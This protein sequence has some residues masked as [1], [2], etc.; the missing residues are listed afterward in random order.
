MSYRKPGFSKPEFAIKRA[1]E[2]IAL[3]RKHQALDALSTIATRRQRAWSKKLETLMIKFLSMCVELNKASKAKESL[4]QFRTACLQQPQSLEIV[5]RHFTKESER[6]AEAVQEGEFEDPLSKVN[7]DPSLVN[8]IK[9]VSL[10][11]YNRQTDSDKVKPWLKF[12]WETY[13]TV[14]EILRNNPKL[15]LLYTETAKQAFAFCCKYNRTNEFR[16]LA[17][18]LRNHLAKHTQLQS[19]ESEE[20][21]AFQLEIRFGQLNAAVTLQLWQEAYKSVEDINVTL[22]APA[23]QPIPTELLANYYSQLE[24]LFWVSNSYSLHAQALQKYTELKVEMDKEAASGPLMAPGEDLTEEQREERAQ[25]RDLQREASKAH[26]KELYTRCLLAALCVPLSDKADDPFTV[27]YDLQKEKEL[28][29][30]SLLD[31]DTHASRGFLLDELI[32]QNIFSKCDPELQRLYDL[33]EVKV[34]PFVFAR[35]INKH[36]AYLSQRDEY[37][38]YCNTL[39]DTSFVKLLQ[40]LSNVYQTMDIGHLGKLV[41]TL[42]LHDIEK[43]IVS[44]HHTTGL[45]CRIDHRNGLVH[46][47][48]SS[49]ESDDLR[50]KLS[51]V[52]RNL[53]KCVEMINPQRKQEVDHRRK[54]AF[55]AIAANIPLERKR[56]LERRGYIEKLKEEREAQEAT[57]L[58]EAA[59]RHRIEKLEAEDREHKRQLTKNQNAAAKKDKKLRDEQE[60]IKAAFMAAQ[61]RQIAAAAGTAPKFA[62]KLE[63]AEMT[64][65]DFV[66]KQLE[67]VVEERRKRETQLSKESVKFDHLVRAQRELEK[68]LLELK[69]AQSNAQQEKYF[70]EQQI[71]KA[72]QEEEAFKTQEALKHRLARITQDYLDYKAKLDQ[73]I[74]ADF[75]KKKAARDSQVD[76]W[77]RDQQQKKLQRQAETQK[78]EEEKARKDLENKQTQQAQQRA[79]PAQPAPSAQ[80]PQPAPSAQPAQP[81]Q[82]AKAG[83]A[84]PWETKGTGA[85]TGPA[86]PW[87]VGP[88]PASVSSARPTGPPPRSDGP[89]RFD[90][91]PRFNDGP[92]RFDGPPRYGDGPSRYDSGPRGGPPPSRADEVDKWDRSKPREATRE[93]A[94][95]APVRGTEPPKPGAPAAR[96]PWEKK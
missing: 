16:G 28:R 11:E 38:Q 9:A 33:L 88:T 74:N 58:K 70:K 46:F 17:T 37:K 69:V 83:S 84:K 62:S 52:T 12:L 22:I 64:S 30:A 63:E 25:Q 24:K 44:A 50:F 53:R 41:P 26:R 54:E 73:Q 86:K 61:L 79:P 90:G 42:T 92:S 81:A 80:P 85:G 45:D 66:K 43:R 29:L 76:K 15:E 68:P 51:D 13:R 23:K 67:H 60:K 5:L 78:A 56:I 40:Q 87:G 65:E 57:A 7:L 21:V 36:V 95:H 6:V 27:T 19:P 82:P 55:H 94:R 20:S 31:I 89:S 93:P 75:V 48:V 18:L 4:H 71:L 39:F 59:D 10:E 1:D 72:K 14:L 91:P 96:K 35:E 49:F 47:N 77:R 3:G 32:N 2:L 34:Q 8:L